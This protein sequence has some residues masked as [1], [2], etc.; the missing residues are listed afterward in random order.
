MGRI[1]FQQIVSKQL[2]ILRNLKHHHVSDL[3]H[4][5]SYI[6]PNVK[7]KDIELLGGK[8]KDQNL[9]FLLFETHCYS[10]LK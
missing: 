7:A 9:N 5:G 8:K 10:A 2:A 4:D 6:V 1:I 3:I